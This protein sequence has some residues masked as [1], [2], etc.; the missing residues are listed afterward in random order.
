MLTASWFT[1]WFTL[2]FI[3]EILAWMY[4]GEIRSWIYED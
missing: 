1:A 3:V 4:R 2:Y